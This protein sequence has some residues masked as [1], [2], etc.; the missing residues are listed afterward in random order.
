M[1][2]VLENSNTILI[3]SSLAAR[4]TSMWSSMSPAQSLLN[5]VGFPWPPM[6]ETVSQPVKAWQK[7]WYCRCLS[8]RASRILFIRI[9]RALWCS[10]MVGAWGMVHQ[11][12]Q[13]ICN[14]C[15]KEQTHSSVF[16]IGFK[17]IW[18]LSG[19]SAS[20]LGISVILCA[21]G[22]DFGSRSMVAMSLQIKFSA[23]W[24]FSSPDWRLAWC[25]RSLISETKHVHSP[26]LWCET[27]CVMV[28]LLELIF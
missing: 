26:L 14:F 3:T 5:R 24:V 9:L 15:P 1:V 13:H 4:K 10:W 23:V 8:E 7:R 18:R 6:E 11:H 27:Q 21:V 16:T 28:L 2:D 22:Y 17:N 12:H 20:W 25:S 19:T